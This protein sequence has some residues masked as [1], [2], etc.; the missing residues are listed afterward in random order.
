MATGS[1]AEGSPG[2]LFG[3]S[4]FYVLSD[5]GAACEMTAAGVRMVHDE[6]RAALEEDGGRCL[7]RLIIEQRR[8]VTPD[9]SSPQPLLLGQ[10]PFDDAFA[11]SRD[12]S[13]LEQSGSAGRCH[14]L[15]ENERSPDNAVTARLGP[16]DQLQPCG[17][18]ASPHGG[19]R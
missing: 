13:S 14:K 12:P 15:S 18:T 19:T 8:C 16:L 3:P 1:P 4:T 6:V 7:A 11:S 5:G 17:D 2:D 9:S 10:V